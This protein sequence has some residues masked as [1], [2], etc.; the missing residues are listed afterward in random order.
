MQF[1]MWA[2]RIGASEGSARCRP[3]N[4]SD[5][6]WSLTLVL[7]KRH[8][9][10]TIQ[11]LS[12]VDTPGRVGSPVVTGS[13]THRLNAAL[14]WLIRDQRLYQVLHQSMTSW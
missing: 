14:R 12:N 13:Q 8:G 3:A 2:V 1:H 11:L 9:H 7:R 10:P 4:S 6:L 5:I